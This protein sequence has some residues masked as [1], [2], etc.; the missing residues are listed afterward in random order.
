M[1]HGTYEHIAV[2]EQGMIAIIE[3]RRGPNN[4]IDTDMVGKR[5]VLVV[6]IG[7]PARTHTR[8]KGCEV[9]HDK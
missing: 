7:P 4:F 2:S 6:L 5:V 9:S 3:V 1:Q 8:R